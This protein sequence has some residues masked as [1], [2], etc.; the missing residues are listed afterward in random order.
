MTTTDQTLAGLQQMRD[1]VATAADG[2]ALVAVA[3]D[4]YSRAMAKLADDTAHLMH[5]LSAQAQAS[6]WAAE[7]G[8]ADAGVRQMLTNALSDAVAGMREDAGLPAEPLS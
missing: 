1:Q 6:A 5:A 4:I 7:L 3:W 2:D 8:L